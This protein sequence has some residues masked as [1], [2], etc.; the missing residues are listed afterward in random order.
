MMFRRGLASL[1]LHVGVLACAFQP[2]SVAATESVEFVA[3]HLAEIAMDNRYAGLPL[4]ATPNNPSASGWNLTAQAAYARTQTGAL[5]I[6]GPMISF[7]ATKHIS[8]AWRLTAFAFLDELSLS[9]GVDHRPLAVLFAAGVPLALPAAAEFTGLSGSARGI[10]A[11][12][13]IRHAGQFWFLHSFEWTAGVLWHRLDLR[14]YRFDFRILEGE[15][16]GATGVVDYSTTYSFVAPFAGIAWPREYGNWNFTPHVQAVLPLPRRGV[17]GH[18]A[19]AGY[20]LRGDMSATG[21]AAPFGDPS[22]TVGLD[23][24]YRPWRLS[25]DVGSL[26]SQAL[27]EPVIHEGISSN[28]LLSASISF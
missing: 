23:F 7:G 19:G 5:S 25:I 2:R 12:V 11:G 22:V 10:G 15:N 18:I 21:G 9:S 20:D 6:D 13:A 16:S 3:E 28:W 14:D 17:V 4:W 1:L 8:E 26:V 27:I 24:T